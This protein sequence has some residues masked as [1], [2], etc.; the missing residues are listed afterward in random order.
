MRLRTMT[1]SAIFIT[2]ISNLLFSQTV[3]ND[4]ESGSRS[5]DIANCWSFP[6][7][8]YITN[9]NSSIISGSY[10]GRTGQLTGSY[11]N[12][13]GV[14]APWIKVNGTGNISWKMKLDGW[15]AVNWR[16]AFL[17]IRSASNI[18]GARDTLYSFSFTS[19]NYSTIQNVSIPITHTGVYQYYIAFAGQGGSTRALIDEIQI[20]GTYWSDPSDDCLPLPTIQDVD[21]DGVPDNAD[22][23]PNDQYRAFSTSFPASG[24][25]TLLF[26]D[27]WPST[28]DFDFNDLVTDYQLQIITNG[29]NQI[30]EIYANFVVRA[31][32]ASFSNGFAFQ[33]DNIANNKITSVSGQKINGSF[34]T[35]SSN[36]T[37]QGQ[38]YVNIPVFDKTE[39][40]LP[41]PGSGSGVNVTFGAPFVTPDTTKIIITLLQNG[42]APTGGSLSINDFSISYFNPYLI[43]NQNRD[44]E[45]HLPNYAPSLKFNTEYFGTSDDGSDPTVSL[46][47]KS[48]DGLPWALNVV[49]S[50]PYSEE[51]NDITDCFKRFID[52]AE[53]NGSDYQDWYENKP[54][55]RNNN[56]FYS[57]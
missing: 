9:P 17:L 11:S 3:S 43:V 37:E 10:T 55:Y 47:F 28:G 39:N 49:N 13:N 25:G 36:N 29:S 34:F 24:Y 1:L 6:G 42:I 45:V 31:V 57:H 4:M 40:V 14:I 53:S 20:S 27:L 7:T 35:L 15:S 23:F 50:V 52:W 18:N 12:M 8:S 5:S 21:N 48:K 54:G 46:Y 56:K 26:E 33:F 51:R 16:R 44:K 41:H 38:N 30:V 32:G 2:S 19:S 22:A